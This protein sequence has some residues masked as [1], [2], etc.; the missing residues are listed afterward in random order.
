MKQIG[1]FTI[2]DNVF[3][4]LET[5]EPIAFKCMGEGFFIWALRSNNPAP[6]I[7]QVQYRIGTS[8]F[9]NETVVAHHA[10]G[11]ILYLLLKYN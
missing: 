2:N 6:T 8:V 11:P 4:L 9:E 1:S 10:V 3:H 5:E 7:K